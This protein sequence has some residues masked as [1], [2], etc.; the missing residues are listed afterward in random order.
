MS[1]SDVIRRKLHDLERR[2]LTAQTQLE[3]EMW[4]VR[5]V[6]L[7]TPFQR[8]TREPVQVAVPGVAKRVRQARL[9]IKKLVCYRDVLAVNLHPGERDWE[10]AKRITMR[11]VTEGGRQTAAAADDG[12]CAG[13]P[14]SVGRDHTSQCSPLC[15]RVCNFTG[16]GRV[17]RR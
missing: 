4:L 5:N 6:V 14:G 10:R 8:A 17:Y 1:C 13:L 11:A 16:E 7:L 15:E 2:I 12:V 3:T 9:E